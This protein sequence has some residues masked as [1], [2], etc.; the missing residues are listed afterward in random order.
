M[1]KIELQDIIMGIFII[2]IH[3]KLK[4]KMKMEQE[5]LLVQFLIIKSNV[6]IM[7]DETCFSM[8]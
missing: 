5:M 6:S 1:E 8:H 3:Q 2:A 7:F 4:L